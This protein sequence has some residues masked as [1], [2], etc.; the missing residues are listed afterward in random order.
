MADK[1]ICYLDIETSG[2]YP[3]SGHVILSIGAVVDRG[4]KKNPI[5][6]FYVE[7]APTAAQ[8]QHAA[9]A[10]LRVNGMTWERLQQNGKPFNQASDEFSAFLVENK[11]KTGKAVIVGHYPA[12]DMGFLEHYMRGALDFIDFPT[13][14]EDVIDVFDLYSI[15]MNRRV[16]PFLNR[17]RGEM[18]AKTVARNLG[19]QEEPEVHNALEGARLAQRNYERAMSLIN[20]GGQDGTTG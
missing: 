3:N 20:T 13:S 15:L 19:V 8:W 16:V 6:E 7:I 10:A 2:L 9:D 5:A 11:V 18:T 4:T 12:F 1:S 14:A 17:R